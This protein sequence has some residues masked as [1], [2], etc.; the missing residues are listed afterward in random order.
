MAS[1]RE[2]SL[3][4]GCCGVVGAPTGTFCAVGALLVAASSARRNARKAS[5]CASCGTPSH[6]HRQASSRQHRCA[7]PAGEG[8]IAC[9]LQ[10]TAMEPKDEVL[11]RRR[12]HFC[13]AQSVSY[14][15]TDPLYAVLGDGQFLVDDKGRSLLD[16]RNN[17][18]HVGWQN[19]RVGAAVA[20]QM[21]E[22]NANSRYIHHT[23]GKLAE[24]LLAKLPP[25]LTKVFFVNSGSEANDLAL[26][27][28]RTHTGGSDV[29]VVDHAYHGHTM[30][31][32]DIS[33][34]KYKHP[35]GRGRASHVHEVILPCSTVTTP[36]ATSIQH[37]VDA[38]DSACKAAA[39]R[40]KQE[41]ANAGSGLAAFIVE[42][43]MSVAG[44][45]LPPTGCLEQAFAK[46]HAA[47]G[48]CIADEVQVG[49][50]RV[51]PAFWGFALGGPAVK[52]DIVTMG[53]PFGNGFPLAAVA[54]TA[55]VAE[56]F[57]NGLEYFNTFGGN[58]VACAAGLAVLDEIEERHL[59]KYAQDLGDYIQKQLQ[60]LAADT[61]GAGALIK[62]VRGAGL[63]IGV[64]FARDAP[65]STSRLREAP[66]GGKHVL[67]PA[68]A[69]TSILCSRLKS[70][71]G[72]LTT[73]DGP[74]HNVLVLKPP[75]VF[76]YADADYL[77]DCMRLE[78]PLIT[79]DD[80]QNFSHTPT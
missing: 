17:V 4:K 25:H 44:V 1:S 72:I 58:P 26:R 63:F 55:A 12:E 49:F 47:G 13:G 73:I 60:E 38:V 16:T 74:H 9:R 22:C 18:A 2:A 68:T 50:G 8:E 51:G 43:G 57:E 14:A 62:A 75:L 70:K 41:V 79:H 29:I 28:A 35:G 80:I 39:T 46:V 59:D 3:L 71:H 5:P 32:L 24:R 36:G 69:E 66:N 7:Q 77:V 10:K 45:I 76:S 30:A 19:A 53:K 78:L 15:N 20:A 56:S 64:E 11:R 21:G 67:S 33:P 54:T 27:L 61:N 6:D 52:P 48:V 40:A 31:C 65:K 23:R 42:S 37:F 34:Y